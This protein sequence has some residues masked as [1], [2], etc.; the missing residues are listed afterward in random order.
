[1][2]ELVEA[3]NGSVMG[4]S[5]DG[6]PPV[7]LQLLPNQWKEVTLKLILMFFSVTIL[8]HER[9]KYIPKYAIPKDEYRHTS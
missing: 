5:F 1:M 2:E 8:Q 6:L 4:V 7:I 9:N 3:I